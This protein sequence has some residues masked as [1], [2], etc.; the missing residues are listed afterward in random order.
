MGLRFLEGDI[1]QSRAYLLVNPVNC[2][3]VMGCGLAE[4]F[5]VRYPE[6]FMPYVHACENGL[7]FP[8]KIHYAYIRERCIVNLPTKRHW[9]DSSLLDDIDEGLSCL[10]SFIKDNNIS[11]CAIPALGCGRGELNYEQVKALLEKYFER[12]LVQCEAYAPST[13]AIVG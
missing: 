8:G 7:I 11:T 9:R 13:G 12:S 3:G 10:K 6:M 1:F 4:Q 2:V 5:K